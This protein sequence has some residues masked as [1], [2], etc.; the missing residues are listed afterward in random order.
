MPRDG[1]ERG[2]HKDGGNGEQQRHMGLLQD[3]LK[4]PQDT[5]SGVR[6]CLGCGKRFHDVFRLA[7]HIKDRHR[8]V[9]QETSRVISRPTMS[10][11]IEF[12]ALEGQSRSTQR[13]SSK[14]H[15]ADRVSYGKKLLEHGGKGQRSGET[16]KS[17]KAPGQKKLSS[18]KKA[19]LREKKGLLK[20]SWSTVVSTLD[21]RIK[22][23][24]EVKSDISER[25]RIAVDRLQKEEI[26]PDEVWDHLQILY[27]KEA[28][29][30]GNVAK[31]N[32]MKDLCLEKIQYIDKRY[33]TTMARKHIVLET[34]VQEHVQEQPRVIKDEGQSERD[35]QNSSGTSVVV[36]YGDEFIQEDGVIIEER[37]KGSESEDEMYDSDD[38]ISSDD[39]FELQWGDTL[40]TWAQNMGHMNLKELSL[41][42]D[43]IN[44]EHARP[45][46]VMDTLDSE[47]DS[48][49]PE[50]LATMAG[51]RGVRIIST[52]EKKPLRTQSEGASRDKD[53]EHRIRTDTCFDTEYHFQQGPC[54]DADNFLQELPMQR[55]TSCALC[56]IPD[57][58]VDGWILHQKSPSHRK[59]L[60]EKAMKEL[61]ISNAIT[62]I[63]MT[64]AG[65]LSLNPKKYTGHDATVEAYVSHTITDELNEQVSLFLS[66]LIAWQERTRMTD[67]MN[68]KKKKRLLCGMREAA[69]AV[70]LGKVKALIVAPNIQPLSGRFPT[71]DKALPS[72]PV[73][74]II[75]ECK[76]RG[77]PAIFALTRRKMGSLLGQRKNVSLFAVLNAQGAEEDLTAITTRLQG[78][79]R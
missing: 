58:G 5:V 23:L 34:R 42:K 37:T 7:Q 4:C 9:S 28:V 33:T 67:P 52:W 32:A 11:C 71:G 73:D 66:K 2:L 10:A 50:D 78:L 19:Y 27:Q 24:Q 29:L 1:H 15:P 12:P 70:K 39:S 79:Q 51:S 57:L 59:I 49:Q 36:G 30:C 45:I 21:D 56:K 47:K 44:D 76:Q 14:A 26:V 6:V 72:Y 38:S 35:L 22:F 61:K 46:I 8:G 20:D 65:N 68:A 16:L 60:M 64:K 54:L 74:S 17:R 77:I 40:Q 31:L 62:A 63:P 53:D 25:K 43:G 48:Q 75:H 41:A 18:L 13:V 55:P 69:K 3:A